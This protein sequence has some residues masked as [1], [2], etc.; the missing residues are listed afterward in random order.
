[1]QRL[2]ISCGKLGQGRV[3]MA[4]PSDVDR[5]V[6]GERNRNNLVPVQVGAQHPGRNGITVQTN[7]QIEQGRTVIDPDAF[8]VRQR[9]EDFLREVERIVFPLLEG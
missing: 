4:D 6:A 5:L 9:A 8:F 1:M 3:F 2:D 7:Q